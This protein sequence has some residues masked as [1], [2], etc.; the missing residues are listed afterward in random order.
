MSEQRPTW[1]EGPEWDGWSPTE[2]PA[3]VARNF[4]DQESDEIAI[5]ISSKAILSIT[6]LDHTTEIACRSTT[7]ARQAAN[8]LAF[9][10]ANGWPEQ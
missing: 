5:E 1:A 2:D 3:W 4:V 6:G 8:L 10:G 7:E 9:A